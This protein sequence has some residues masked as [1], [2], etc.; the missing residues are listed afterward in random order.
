MAK[1]QLYKTNE[2]Y[3][4]SDPG[5]AY[6]NA[7]GQYIGDYGSPRNPAFF[8]PDFEELLA[9]V[10]QRNRAAYG[11]LTTD[12][13]ESLG[14]A[15]LLASGAL[16][17]ALARAQIGLGQQT[18]GDI[19]NLYGAEYGR[20]GGFETNRALGLLGGDYEKGQR[21]DEREFQMLMQTL[22]LIPGAASFIPGFAGMF[23]GAGKV[24]TKGAYGDSVT[25]AAPSPWGD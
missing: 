20:K 15:G 10:R 9:T 7:Y 16:P 21:D 8:G 1:Q 17:D 4:S 12:I 22:A 13:R 6:K 23:K 19:T 18:L 2:G 14:S 3:T 5:A 11:G 24:K 25:T